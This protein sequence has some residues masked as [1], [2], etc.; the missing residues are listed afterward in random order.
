MESLTPGRRTFLKYFGRAAA[1]KKKARTTA[2]ER[3]AQ[4]VWTAH[5]H[6]E[7]EKMRTKPK[8]STASPRDPL[9]KSAMEGGRKNV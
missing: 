3:H 1:K 7:A 6:S 4:R 5:V 9:E 2:Q 8:K